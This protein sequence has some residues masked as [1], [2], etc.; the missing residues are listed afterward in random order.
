VA[1][2]IPFYRKA[3]PELSNF[4]LTIQMSTDLAYWKGGYLPNHWQSTPSRTRV[5]FFYTYA[6]FFA[7]C[8]KFSILHGYRSEPVTR[9]HTFS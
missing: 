2:L 4:E 3:L 9:S 1:E 6:A 7:T 5:W 8:L